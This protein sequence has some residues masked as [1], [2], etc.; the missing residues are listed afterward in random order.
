M[1]R[2]HNRARIPSRRRQVVIFLLMVHGGGLKPRSSLGA[3]RDNLHNKARANPLILNPLRE[4]K[5]PGQQEW[6]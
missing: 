6:R 5:R 3:T 2:G 4:E 1:M